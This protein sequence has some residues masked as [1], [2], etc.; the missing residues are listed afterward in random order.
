MA[1][2]ISYQWAGVAMLRAT[3]DPSPADI[4]QGLNLD[5]P[6]STRTWLVRIWQRPDIRNALLSASP[7]LG[8]TVES[9]V[10]GTPPA[11]RQ[12]RRAALSVI[13][14]LLRWRH[15][16]TPFGLFA[17]A[18]P[19][20]VGVAPHVRWGHD[21]PVRL[22]ADGE[23]I[24]DVIQH[25]ES[26]AELLER[27]PVLANNTAYIRGDRLAAPGPPADGHARLMAPVEISLRLSRPVKAAMKAAQSPILY[28][29]LREHLTALFPAG[30]GG[31]IDGVLRELLTQ[32]LLITSLRPSMTDLDALDHVCAELKK[33]DAHSLPHVGAYARS[34]YD[35]RDDL[36]SHDESATTTNL[37][38]LTTRMA[39]QSSIAPV[40]ILVDTVLNGSVQLPTEVITE[41]QKAVTLLHRLS[42]HPYGYPHWRDYHR[43][44]RAQYGVGATVP[45]LEL[46]ADSGLGW[47]AG[48]TGSERR[49]AP[50][51]L[52]DRDAVMLK[53][54]QQTGHGDLDLD[55]PTIA[56]LVEAGGIDEPLFA[57]RCEVGFEVHAPSTRNLVQGAFTIEITAVPR[58]GSS[59]FGR[60]AHLLPADQ[61]RL[62]ADSYTTRPDAITAQLSFGPRRR[63]N[64]N[65][66]RTPQLLPCVIP[67]AEHP[68]EGAT[69]ISVDDIGVTADARSLHLVQLSTGRSID[70]RVL[71][72]LEAGIQTPPLAR[73]L[74]E[75]AGARHAVYKP[76]DFG[77][78]ASRLPYLPRVR[79]GRTTLA[80][81]RWLLD[82]RG[83]PARTAPH[84]KWEEAFTTW[85]MRMNVPRYVCLM[86]YDQ[87]LPLDLHHPVHRRLVRSRMYEGP[88]LELRQGM[89]PDAHGW[90][91]RA[92]DVILPFTRTTPTSRSLPELRPSTDVQEPVQF[93]GTGS[94]LQMHLHTHPDR[95]DEIL[96]RHLPRLVAAL[97][98]EP[99][100]WFTRHRQL[101]RPETGQHLQLNL[102]VAAA[103]HAA[104]AGAV[105][106]WA[107]ELHHQRLLAHLTLEPYRPQTGRFG[108]RTAME[109]A[110][111]LFAADSTT[112][113]AQIRLTSRSPISR[114]AVTAASLVDLATRFLPSVEDGWRWLIENTPAHGR[115]DRADRTEALQL[116]AAAGGDDLSGAWGERARTLTAYR[117]ALGV[118]GHDPGTVLRSLLHQHH[119]RAHGVDPT[120]EAATLHLARTVALR[121]QPSKAAR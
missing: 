13:S 104:V 40:P 81:A 7:V 26:D 111:V 44:F 65:V 61:Q 57:D 107:T 102:H 17:G 85:R 19:L 80:P 73:F 34:L 48:Y 1:D 14:Y 59:M 82:N 47:P 106:Q 77:A 37:Q 92:H 89:D 88:G 118:E 84:H 114:R 117:H 101:A 115:P 39:A 100:W 86:E 18:A 69:S 32:N 63:R 36:A 121:H 3:T 23:W 98:T 62:I 70:A 78:A 30:A 45:V 16:P 64:E 43:R 91:G 10:R 66:A 15:R 31:K 28:Q 51:L 99:T 55:E 93:P 72:A 38:A 54:L 33:V 21:H 9:I 67:L 25:L 11:P 29:D 79:Y 68:A 110:H 103:D 94:V 42:P 75:V 50:A 41:V 20:T 56:E 83:M 71:H 27:L 35:L 46:V 52:T 58:P 8:A 53:L 116:D 74:A 6:V 113:L 95:F 76:F 24:S 97:D 2:A 109:A 4:P 90:I 119:V 108:A 105:N 22:R 5:D 49:K 87:R 112:A 60:F 120:A 96:D 12:I